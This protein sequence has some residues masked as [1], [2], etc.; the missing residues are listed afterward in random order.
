[1][2]SSSFR[3]FS[4]LIRTNEIL[5]ESSLLLTSSFESSLNFLKE[6]KDLEVSTCSEDRFF[7]DESG[8]TLSRSSNIFGVRVLTL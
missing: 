8:K 5:L 6:S 1:M 2:F 3:L 4:D 7:H